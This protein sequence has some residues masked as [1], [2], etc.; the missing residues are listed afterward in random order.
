[1]NPFY[2][3]G[4]R[5]DSRVEQ[6]E[7]QEETTFIEHMMRR[8]RYWYPVHSVIGVLFYFCIAQ[9]ALLSPPYRGDLSTY[10]GSGMELSDLA[11]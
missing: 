11:L 9:N 2:P 1:M 8:S 6:Q 5:H 7:R 10:G 3:S 4:D